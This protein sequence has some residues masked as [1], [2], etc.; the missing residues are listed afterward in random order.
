MSIVGGFFPRKEPHSLAPEVWAGEEGRLACLAPGL[1]SSHG[2]VT[3]L[4]S[5]EWHRGGHWLV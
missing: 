5:S 1:M 4:F 2:L 3:G